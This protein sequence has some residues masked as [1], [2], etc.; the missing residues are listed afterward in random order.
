MEQIWNK[1]SQYGT[2]MYGNHKIMFF[3]LQICIQSCLYLMLITTI[4]NFPNIIYE[5]VSLNNKN[6]EIHISSAF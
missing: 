6:I 4:A 5:Y 3:Y 1:F 2:N